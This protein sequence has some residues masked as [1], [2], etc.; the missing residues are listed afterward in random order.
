MEFLYLQEIVLSTLAI[1][2]DNVSLLVIMIPLLIIIEL[3]LIFTVLAGIITWYFRSKLRPPLKITPSVTVGITCYSEGDDI[4]K[5]VVTLCEQVYPGKIEIIIIIDGAIQNK[6]TYRAAIEIQKIQSRYKNRKI[7]VLPKWKR[8]GRVSSSNAALSMAKGELFIAVDGDS[9]FNNNMVYEIAKEFEDPDVP[10]VSGSLKVRNRDVSLITKMQAIEYMISM[11]GGKTGL[12]EWNLINNISGAFGAFRTDFVKQIG[13]WDTHSGED[14]DLTLRIQQY[15]GRHKNIRIP[16]AAKAIGHTDAPTTITDITKQRNRWDGDL[17]FIYFRKHRH[18][19]SPKLLGWK[20]YIFTLVY[21]VVQN[22]VM[23][24]LV[25]GFNFWVVSM[26]GFYPLLG[27]LC[28]QYIAYIGMTYINFIFY[29]FAIADKP[30]NDFK[31]LLWIPLFPVFTL[32]MRG[33]SVFG[34]FNEVFRRSHEES[35]M[36]PWWVLKKSDKF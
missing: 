14:L 12:A 33:V 3:P 35:S 34:I 26:Y 15:M 17:I 6:D 36:A 21:G 13:G 18:A 16:F 9:S 29:L 10:A 19:F 32:Y 25:I 4:K 24:L 8:G 28:L 2:K 5:T 1:I 31:M 23:P 11:E 22:V 20:R 30:K 27:M 7:I